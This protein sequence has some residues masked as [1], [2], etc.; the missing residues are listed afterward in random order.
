MIKIVTIAVHT[1]HPRI[2]IKTVNNVIRIVVIVT[3]T[4]INIGVATPIGMIIRTKKE[5]IKIGTIKV[6]GLNFKEKTRLFK[7]T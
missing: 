7:L 3:K 6:A 5:E 2:T 4:K 1:N